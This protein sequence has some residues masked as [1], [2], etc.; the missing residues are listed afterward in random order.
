MRIGVALSDSLGLTAQPLTV[1]Q[2]QGTQQDLI[3][4][5]QLVD[6][7]QV[8]QVIVGLPINMDGTESKQT[9]KIRDFAGKLAGRLNIPLF[10]V[11]E[12]LTSKQAERMMSDSGV[13]SKDQ[14]GKVDQVAAAIL[15]DS[16]LK[17]APLT[18]V[19]RP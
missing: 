5:G 19:P 9:Q 13:K 4:I 14:R 7:H 11:D 12:R 17:G 18:E 1:L 3:T 16:A 2:S 15:L 6:E 10:F 8:S